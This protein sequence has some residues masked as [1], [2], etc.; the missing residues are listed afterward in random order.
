MSYPHAQ[1]AVISEERLIELLNGV[2]P[3]QD[4]IRELCLAYMNIPFIESLVARLAGTDGHPAMTLEQLQDALT[5]QGWT[6]GGT[7]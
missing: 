1:P 3:T 2:Q 5:R 7:R 6:E 4:E